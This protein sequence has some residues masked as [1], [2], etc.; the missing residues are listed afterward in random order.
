[1]G[2]TTEGTGNGTNVNPNTNTDNNTNG[3]TNNNNTQNGSNV[4][5]DIK[6]VGD[7]VVNGV[8][9]AG[10]AVKDTVDGAMMR[11][12]EACW[13]ERSA[14]SVRT[15][16]IIVCPV[17]SI[18]VFGMDIIR[19]RHWANGMTVLVHEPQSERYMWDVECVTMANFKWQ[20]SR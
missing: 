13:M 11:P 7:D 4:G 8:E 19:G 1:M 14:R 17:C 6:D 9:D 2:N 10:N 12:Y 5:N 15:H 18:V 3:T 20:S 16:G